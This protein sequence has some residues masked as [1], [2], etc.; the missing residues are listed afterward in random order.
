VVRGGKW[1]D[2]AVNCRSAIRRESDPLA[3]V[4]GHGFRLALSIVGGPDD[5][6]EDKKE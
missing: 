4:F 1:N 3:S 2:V 6:G 5:S